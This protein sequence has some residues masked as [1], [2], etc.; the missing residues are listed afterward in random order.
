VRETPDSIFNPKEVCV[1]LLTRLVDDL[2][3]LIGRP[4]TMLVVTA[5]SVGFFIA[6]LVS[7][8]QQVL[9]INL[10]TVLTFLLLFPLQHSQNRDSLAMQAK[11]DE[12]LHA[13]PGAR[14]SLTRLEDRSEKD[15]EGMRRG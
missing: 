2:T 7:E 9:M 5:V 13:I 15:I 8:D 1:K 3:T 4:V 11:L 6:S 10:L 12:L 14:N